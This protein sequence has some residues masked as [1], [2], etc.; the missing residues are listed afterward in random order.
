M[1]RLS[2]K[3]RRRRNSSELADPMS[4]NLSD[5]VESTEIEPLP[6]SYVDE[7]E[8][9]EIEPPAGPYVDE[10]ETRRPLSP[11]VGTAAEMCGRPEQLDILDERLRELMNNPRTLDA[12]ERDLVPIPATVNREGYFGERHLAY[13]LSG[14]ADLRM[15]EQ[16]APSACYSHVLDFGGAS[17]RFARHIPLANPSAQVTIADL[18]INHVDWVDRHFSSSVRAIKVNAIPH[19]PLADASVT[20]CVGLSVFT[21]I[22]VYET[23]WLAEINRVLAKDCYAVLTI[24]SE[25]SWTAIPSRPWMIEVLN[26]DPRFAEAYRP[27]APM[28]RERLVFKHV[29]T[30]KDYNVNVFMSAAYIRRAWSRWFEVVAIAPLAHHGFQTAVVLRKTS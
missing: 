21:H 25:H 28:P 27:D 22:D 17:G 5:S 23:G 6:G 15:V 8:V 10:L 19:F 13:W 16:L 7:V 29:S 18:N 24:H 11:S 3:L 30:S 26:H 20:L 1:P 12:F 4:A 2:K 14:I 9:R